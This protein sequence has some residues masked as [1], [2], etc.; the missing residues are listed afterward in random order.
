M[1]MMKIQCML[2]SSRS[3]DWFTWWWK[4]E[5]YTN[6]WFILADHCY[7]EDPS[8]AD[9]DEETEKHHQAAE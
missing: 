3:N 9:G 5:T 2:I 4:L 6:T 7:D 8:K 1:A